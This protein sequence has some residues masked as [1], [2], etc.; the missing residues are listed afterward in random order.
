MRGALTF[1]EREQEL[2]S[3]PSSPSPAASPAASPAVHLRPPPS[4]LRHPIAYK[5]QPP[6]HNPLPPSDGMVI[7]AGEKEQEAEGD[8]EG[9]LVEE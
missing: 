2:P 6:P 1:Y 3:G 4:S 8:E 9:C 7:P 5:Q